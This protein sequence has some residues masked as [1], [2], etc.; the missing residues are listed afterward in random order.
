MRTTGQP[1][2][3]LFPKRWPL[4]NPNR[5]KSI[6]NKHKVKH[7]RNSDT[8]TG[9]RDH[10][11]TTALERSVMNYWEGIKLVSRAKPHPPSLMW[12]KHLVDCSVRM[13]TL[14]LVN[15]SSRSTNKSR[16]ITMKKERR[17]LNRYSVLHDRWRSLVCQTTPLEI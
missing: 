14:S 13:T 16:L 5:T 15:E 17:G 11:S 12:Y 1:S 3:Q 7:H 4:S 9:N 8:K 2:G 6:M 10:I